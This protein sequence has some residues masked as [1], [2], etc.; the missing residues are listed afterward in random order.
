[1]RIFANSQ[2]G[3]LLDPDH[4]H[5]ALGGRRQGAMTPAERKRLRKRAP[6]RGGYA[7]TPGSGP[8]DQRCWDCQ[9]RRLVES[10]ARKRF[11]KC[12]L[13]KWT[14]GAATDIRLR[15][16]ACSR[17]VAGDPPEARDV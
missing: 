1:M 12:A 14:H 8:K 4:V 2:T 17:F 6:S 3:E 7:A 10:P 16:V 13:V 9:N 15:S 5:E 11:W